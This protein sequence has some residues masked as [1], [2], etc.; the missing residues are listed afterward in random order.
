MTSEP[1]REDD[2]GHGYVAGGG[3]DGEIVGNLSA[4]AD[5]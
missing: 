3:T 4:K 2:A 5:K 1:W